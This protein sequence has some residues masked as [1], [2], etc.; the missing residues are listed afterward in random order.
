M[1]WRL[2]FSPSSY[3]SHTPSSPPISETNSTQRDQA[4]QSIL[5]IYQAY[6]L[7]R[8]RRV[9]TPTAPF[10]PRM[11]VYNDPD[12]PNVIVTFELP[13][14]RISDVSI[15]V[16]KPGMLLIQGDRRPR[17]G[18]PRAHPSVRGHQETE[19][20]DMDVDSQTS[21]HTQLDTRYF[22]CQELRY[23]SFRRAIH[24]P[25]GADASCIKANLS[26]GLLTVSCPRSPAS[27][28]RVATPERSPI[29]HPISSARAD[30]GDSTHVSTSIAVAIL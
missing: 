19:T 7:G 4:L 10:R 5:A 26:E 16:P 12:L 29:E 24:L 11:E 23:G 2:F 28:R 18:R 1:M 3:M 20:V 25:S 8:L 13:G 30:P 9:P 6:R 14:V 15:T 27:P 22:P 21:G 17:Y